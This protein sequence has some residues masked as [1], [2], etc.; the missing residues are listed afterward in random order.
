MG[1]RFIDLRSIAIGASLPCDPH[2]MIPK[3]GRRP[4]PGG[5]RRSISFPASAGRSRRRRAADTGSSA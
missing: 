5:D 2:M 4:R 3:V 1:K